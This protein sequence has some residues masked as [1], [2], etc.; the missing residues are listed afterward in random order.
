M[1]SPRFFAIDLLI[2]I[3]V[4]IMVG[5]N[6]QFTWAQPPV[7]NPGQIR[8]AAQASGLEPLGNVPVPVPNLAAAGVLNPNNPKADQDLLR[9]GK[10]FFWDQQ[11][12]SDGQACGSCHFEAGA[13]RR[14][15]NQ[16][17]PDTREG[18]YRSRLAMSEM[19]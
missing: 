5:F 6:P 9:L 1:K 3:L 8:A 19:W 2:S 18:P 14:A 4:L 13:D 16:L 17:N 10:A 15:K 7:V 12:G 11:V